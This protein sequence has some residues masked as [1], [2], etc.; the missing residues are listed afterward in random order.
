MERIKLGVDVG[1]TTIKLVALD[2]KENVIYKKYERHHSKINDT[3]VRLISDFNNEIKINEVAFNITGSAGLGLANRFDFN[4]VQEV[5]CAYYAVNKLYDEVD[6]IIE[7]GGEDAKVIFIDNGNIEQRM[8]GTCAGGT[9]AFI[10]QMAQLLRV[11]VNEL[12]TLASKANKIYDISSRCGVFAK[13]DIQPLLN[14]GAQKE[15]IAISVYQAI[16]NQTIIGLAQGREIKGK[17]CFLGGPLTFSDQLRIRFNET[18]K[19]ENSFIPDDSEIFVAYGCALYPS[20]NITNLET[21]IDELAKDSAVESNKYLPPLFK[22]ENEYQNFLTRHNHD[23]EYDDIKTYCG[24]AYLGIDAGSTTTKMVLISED[25]KLLFEYYGANDGNPLDIVKR[26]LIKIYEAIDNRIT[27]K[28]AY[29]TGYGEQLIKNAFCLDGGQVETI[30]HF[31]AAKFFLPDVEFV[32]DIGGQDMKYFT[33]DKGVISSIVLNEACSS[34]CGSFISTYATSLGYSIEEFAKLAR[35]AKRPLDLGTRC[36]VFMNSGIKQAL[37]M[38]VGIEDISASLAISVVKN[39]LYKVIRATNFKEDFGTKVLVQ[40]G[41][42]YNDAILKAFEDEI[43]FEVIRPKIAGLMGAFG[44]ALIAKEKVKDKSSLLS[45]DKVKS[46]VYQANNVTC[47]LCSNHCSL[48]INKF[49]SG[50]QFIAN[51]KCSKP[52][53]KNKEVEEYANMYRYKINLLQSY[54]DKQFEYELTVGIPRALNM[55]ENIPFWIGFFNSLKIKVVVSDLTNMSLIK[56][57]QHTIPSDT[58]CYPAKIVHGHIINLQ[59]KEIKNIFYPNMPYN[60]M[61]SLNLQ[62]HYN[63]PVVGCYPELINSNFE[64]DNCQFIMPYLSFENEKEFIKVMY[65][66]MFK[67]KKTSKIALKEAYRAGKRLLNQFREEIFVEGDRVLEEVINNNQRALVL[68]GRPYHIDPEINHG[69][70]R[71]IND[72]GC[73]VLSEDSFRLDDSN[74]SGVLNQWTY[75]NRMYNSAFKIA[76]HDNINLVQ[77]VSFGCGIDA[78][79]SDE[80]KKILE[81]NGKLYTQIKIDDISNIGSANIRIRSLLNVME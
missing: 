35:Q 1:S 44:A 56:K 38:Q 54:I 2:E 41:T 47:K 22:D 55:Y 25:N 4:F 46:F 13:N 72:L 52:L 32:L 60:E 21:L 67:I 23:A 68:A 76:G 19:L 27:I 78:I 7:L 37:A 75:H 40:G 11:D 12:N 20:D 69:I 24:N 29:S 70:D 48:T 57:G 50:E 64:F 62:N 63:C 65:N 18:L 43:G 39:A 73:V 16:V 17:V 26:E 45:F 14:Q 80:V 61:E 66:E 6:V 8:N 10:D 30:C 5:S 51:N 71:L 53:K 15:D 36:T 34:G 49:S 74:K 79:T 33:I 42:F 9:G 59:E 58:V 31:E 3:L 81:D 28:G 77:L